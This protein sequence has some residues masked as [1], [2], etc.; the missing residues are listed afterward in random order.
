MGD[1]HIW[2]TDME[3]GGP[4]HNANPIASSLA[5]QRSAAELDELLARL[6][7]GSRGD[8]VPEAMD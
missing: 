3:T 5:P 6:L 8:G 1:M 7:S 2:E 4:S